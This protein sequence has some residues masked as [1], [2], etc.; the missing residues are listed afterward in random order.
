MRS[1]TSVVKQDMSILVHPRQLTSS[2]AD[3]K[4]IVL[5]ASSLPKEKKEQIYNNERI[6]GARAFDIDVI[7]SRTIKLDRMIPSL[8]EFVEHMKRL[9]INASDEILAYDDNGLKGATRAFWMLNVYG[10]ENVKLL[11]GGFDHYK[12][13]KKPVEMGEETWLDKFHTGGNMT[14][15]REFISGRTP[16]VE[17]VDAR[18][19]SE[20]RGETTDGGHIP[21][22]KNVPL[23]LLLE[24]NYTFKKQ[25]EIEKVFKEKNI[26]LSKRII[27][28][29]TTGTS[30]TVLYVALRL[31]GKNDVS[32]YDG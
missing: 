30:S 14:H 11:E 19:E 15:I 1:L 20:F 21:L 17:L 10:N 9:G 16:N 24:P 25:Q 12:E 6:P 4:V 22:S 7:S 32:V 27:C 23:E 2:I 8:T 13:L 31:L 5:H 29:S 26:D 28:S 18:P 3:D